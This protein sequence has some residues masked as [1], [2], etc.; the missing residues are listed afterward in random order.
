MDE[1]N[2]TRSL[3]RSL[4]YLFIYLFISFNPLAPRTGE[5]QKK[6]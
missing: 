6:T 5:I 4:T 2:V 3:A 1:K